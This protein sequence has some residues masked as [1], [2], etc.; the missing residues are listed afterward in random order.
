MSV[1]KKRPTSTPHGN[2]PTTTTSTSTH[3][4]STLPRTHRR[5][6]SDGAPLIQKGDLLD[7]D[8]HTSNKHKSSE[9]G[10]GRNPS[11]VSGTHRRDASPRKVHVRPRTPSSTQPHQATNAR[12]ARN[13]RNSRDP[14]PPHPHHPSQPSTHPAAQPSATP[15]NQAKEDSKRTSLLAKTFSWRNKQGPQP[16]PSTQSTLPATQEEHPLTQGREER[17]SRSVRDLLAFLTHI[18]TPQD[19]RTSTGSARDS[20]ADEVSN[21]KVTFR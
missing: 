15:T 6:S 17:K 12:A 11:I 8:S 7:P 1:P 3:T 9:V 21:S 10:R 16:S 5:G 14:S 4:S 20:T 19:T 13:S 18:Q 2:A